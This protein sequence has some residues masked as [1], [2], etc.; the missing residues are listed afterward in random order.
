MIDTALIAMA[1]SIFPEFLVYFF[2][3]EKEDSVAFTFCFDCQEA[4]SQI[5]VTLIVKIFFCTWFPL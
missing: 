2:F 3:M 5:C 1:M 4:H